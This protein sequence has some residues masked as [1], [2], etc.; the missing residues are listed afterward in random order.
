MKILIVRRQEYE[1]LCRCDRF[2][3]KGEHNEE[4]ERLYFLGIL[5][6]DFNNEFYSSGR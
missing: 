2:R 6:E 4:S 3:G 1:N 5:H